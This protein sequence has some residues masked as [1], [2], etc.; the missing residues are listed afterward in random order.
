MNLECKKRGSS[1]EV[2]HTNKNA[3]KGVQAVD[4]H[5]ICVIII[6]SI[7]ENTTHSYRFL[8]HLDYIY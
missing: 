1:F 6:V 3:F 4:K 8:S 7:K 2:V 5:I